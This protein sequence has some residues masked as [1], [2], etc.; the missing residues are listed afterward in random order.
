MTAS[1]KSRTLSMTQIRD[2]VEHLCELGFTGTQTGTTLAQITNARIMLM[3]Y[4][5]AG[6]LKFHHGDC[7]GSDA[8]IHRVAKR[9]GYQIHVHPPSDPKKRAWCKADVLYPDKPYLIRNK[10]IISDTNILLATPKGPEEL[11]SG[12]WSTIRL[13]R[14]RRWIKKIYIIYP[15]GRIDLEE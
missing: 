1:R 10:D 2:S 6:T 14:Q 13:A 15:D 5:L 4:W 12:T 3:E 7:V 11:R 8:E 9:I